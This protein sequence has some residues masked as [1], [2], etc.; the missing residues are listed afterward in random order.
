MKARLK[1]YKK[2]QFGE[3]GIIEMKVW[4]LKK[5]AF[6]PLGYKYSFVLVKQKKRLLGYDNH[7]RKGSHKHIGDAEYN[8]E[9]KSIQK[10]IEDFENEIAGLIK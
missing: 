4:E 3:D 7:E 1:F 5:D 9:F 2:E 8:Y 6:Y 10:L